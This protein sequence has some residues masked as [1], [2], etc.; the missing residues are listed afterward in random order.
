MNTI[1]N[2]LLK[3]NGQ[4]NC[5]NES[6]SQ[7][8]SDDLASLW[9]NYTDRVK[10]EAPYV[11]V[12]DGG[13]TIR[14]GSI[15]RGCQAC[16]SGSWDCIFLTLQCNLACSFCCSPANKNGNIPLSAVGETIAEVVTNYRLNQPDGVSFSGGEPFLAFSNLIKN[17]KKVRKELPNTYIW[18]YTNGILAD[19]EKLLMLNDSGVDEIRFNMAATGYQN[20]AVL[21]NVYNAS[22]ILKNVTV[23]C[24]AVPA[25]ESKLLKSLKSW[26]NVGVRYINLHE[27]MYEPGTP[28][29]LLD[30]DKVGLVTPDGHKTYVHPESRITILN[31]MK[32]VHDAGL[33]LSINECSLQNKIRQVRGRR[34]FIGRLLEK[35]PYATERLTDEN[36]LESICGI[37]PEG[38][39]FY[40]HPQKLFLAMQKFPSYQ[41]I[42][43]WRVP[44]LTIR[45]GKDWLRFEIV[46]S[47]REG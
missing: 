44:P 35:M 28:S 26:E 30:W 2:L 23:E 14:L 27:L 32:L 22:R 21:K 29:S 40:L 31:T 46:S 24:P 45:S 34:E 47:G 12:E 42:R 15:S 16:K 5:M 9:K 38:R 8:C 4:E 25:E 41:F 20:A 13:E 33:Q 37:S 17:I 7:G 10:S 18:I 39:I 1:E 19:R 11:N 3:I 36:Y 43:L 6:A